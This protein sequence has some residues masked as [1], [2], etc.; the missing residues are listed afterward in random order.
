MADLDPV[1][2]RIH[3]H[4]QHARM[5]QVDRAAAAGEV[6]VEPRIFR[7]QPVIGGVVDAAKRQRRAEMVALGGVVIDDVEHHLDAGVMQPRH[8]GSKGIECIV[9]RVARLGGKE[10]Q[11]VVAPVV[12][13]LLLD[14]HPIVDQAVDRQQFDRGDAETLEMIDHRGRREPAIGAAQTRRYVVALLGQALDV[15]FIDD[16]VFPGNVRPRFAAAPVEGFVDDD[17]LRHAAGVVTPVEGEIFARAAGA[18]GEM[19]V[20]PDQPAG[21]PLG[22]GVEQQ[23]VGV[24]AVPMLGRIGAVDAVAIELSRARRR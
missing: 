6:V 19:R 7:L 20:A 14:Q 1:A 3:H 8:R 5:G 24:E 23:L 21:E 17:S 15:G 12:R 2:Q 10:R 9:L 4:L 11:R 18:I 13:E 22:I 16:G